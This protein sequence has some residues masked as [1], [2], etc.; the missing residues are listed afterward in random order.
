MAEYIDSATI[1][2]NIYADGWESKYPVPGTPAN[3]NFADAT[4]MTTT[5][6]GSLTGQ[7]TKDAYWEAGEPCLAG[8]SSYAPGDQSV[9]YKFTPAVSG[10]Y[11]ITFD[12]ITKNSDGSFGSLSM[13]M[14]KST[15]LSDFAQPFPQE[16]LA[17]IDGSFVSVG[18]GESMTIYRY[19]ESGITYTFKL[20]SEY[21]ELFG[22]NG[23]TNGN[24]KTVNFNMSWDLETGLTLPANDD[25]A[26]AIVFGTT[27]PDSVSG[28]TVD[29]TAEIGELNSGTTQQSVWY[30][31]TPATTATYKFV[32]PL[33]SFVPAGPGSAY[34]QCDIF[35][36]TGV[37]DVWDL[38]FANNWVT[39]FGVE[40][41]SQE[42]G[43]G[44]HQL[45]AGTLYYFRVYSGH[46]VFNN[47]VGDFEL[48]ISELPPVDNDDFADAEPISGASGNIEFVTAG[49]TFEIGSEPDSYYYNDPQDQGSVWFDWTCPATGDYVFKVECTLDN[50]TATQ[51]SYD[52]A[53]WE[54]AVLNSLTKIARN[55][56]GSQNTEGRPRGSA[57]SIGFHGINGT[58]YKIQVV[59]YQQVTSDTKLSWRTNTVTGNTTGTALTF[60]DGRIDNFGN[61]ETEP[62]PNFVALLENHPEWWFTDGQVGA[63]KWFKRDI[64]DDQVIEISGSMWDGSP[65]ASLF[66]LL[67]NYLGLIAYKGVDYASLV[68]A[69][70][71]VAQNSVPAA[72][73]I[74]QGNTFISPNS[75]QN[76][77]T[78]ASKDFA[79][80][81][82]PCEAGETLWIAV[83][84]L[85]DNSYPTAT[86]ED[87]QQFEVDLHVDSAPPPNDNRAAL[88]SSPLVNDSDY[89][90]G[91]SKY[92]SFFCEREAGQG[93]GATVEGTTE[94]GDPATIAGFAATRT[95]WYLMTITKPGFYKIWVE[96]P[97]DC[98]LGI[99]RYN[100]SATLG[101]LIAEDDDSG[102]GNQPEIIHEFTGPDADFD[103]YWLGVDS[104]TEGSFVVKYQ[105]QSD[106]TPPGN[107]DFAN[108]TVISSLPFTVAGTTVDATA[109]PAEV[110]PE[111]MGV[112]PKD[113]VW[114]KYVADHTGTLRVR[115]DE[116]SQN[117]D[118]YVYVDVFKGTTLANLV[119]WPDPPPFW[120]KGVFLADAIEDPGE[121]VFN[122]VEF[123][124]ENGETYYIRV[125]TE[126]GG[127][128]DFNIYVDDAFVYINIQPSG[129][130]EMHGTLVDDAE[131]Y[132]DI[133]VSSVEIFDAAL[134]VDSAEVYVNIQTSGV[135]FPAKEYLDEATVPITIS[136]D[137]HDCQ[138]TW[139]S[140]GIVARV[141]DRFETSVNG[142]WLGTVAY[143]RFD[144]IAGDGLEEC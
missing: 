55:W 100:F 91:R 18:T 139:S 22:I 62:P 123:Q 133:Q 134:T 121:N 40:D 115:C 30:K 19:L 15:T 42:D 14:L 88:L 125:Q 136:I 127:S 69:E 27:L 78:D 35:D 90:I 63:V 95:V 114:Y 37:T 66:M 96:S 34:V 72:M 65:T 17:A 86:V 87:A 21:W 47:Y 137:S 94:A 124:V 58:H 6:P 12:N 102:P 79:V 82:I 38:S 142:R 93:V 52:L 45:Q 122:A 132:I 140:S 76:I 68:V 138:T 9:W 43:V 83:F 80:M 71:T 126:E 33:A 92:N 3:D 74:S 61:D 116:I 108:A 119:R 118:W 48:E 44:I 84:G 143:R 39:S 54:G 60:P 109:E 7:T 130:D 99:Y 98:V 49:C 13:V 23:R 113:T 106:G 104:K 73:M 144:V 16:K 64:A 25:F 36:G 112:G 129:F 110:D 10:L 31:F 105:R 28:T 53:I 46:G 29:A 67:G 26:D 20:Y 81:H 4:I 135:D 117:I 141:W 1:Y 77:F 85:Y 131:V 2:I 57:T 24:I 70:T 107:D 101:T 41:D 97:V 103:H 32:F 89:W 11:L 128:E 120:S 8:S 111:E 5:L 56:S 51:P 75:Y 50:A 59:N